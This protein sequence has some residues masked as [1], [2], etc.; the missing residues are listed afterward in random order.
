M[1]KSLGV[2]VGGSGDGEGTAHILRHLAGDREGEGVDGG[3]GA[4]VSAIY[5]D[6]GGN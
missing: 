6:G 3:S 1:E 2:H 5:L 4:G